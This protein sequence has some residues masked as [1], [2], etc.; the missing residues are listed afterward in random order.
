[1]RRVL[2]YL[3][4]A[5]VFYVGTVDVKAPK[6]RPHSFVMIFDGKLCFTTN[7]QKPTYLQLSQNPYIEICTMGKD[8]RWLRLRGEATFITSPESKAAVLE[9]MPSLKQ[10]YSVE[11]NLLEVFALEHAVADF[12]SMADASETVEW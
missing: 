9:T 10:M 4:D 1:M 12:C 2:D 7:N 3:N 11:D 5:R 6:I 8:G